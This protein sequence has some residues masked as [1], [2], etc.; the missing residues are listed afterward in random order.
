M[1]AGFGVDT[2]VFLVFTLVI[3]VS[4]VLVILARQ[5]IHATVYLTFVLL[6]VAGIFLLL[7]AELLAAIQVL[8][9]VGA[10]VTLMLFTIMLTTP[11]EEEEAA[12]P[13][14]PGFTEE[15]L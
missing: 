3:A 15:A 13:A 14:A 4:S 2:L 7:G 8:I 5:L 11:F 1:A 9:Y 10:V 6:G 12:P